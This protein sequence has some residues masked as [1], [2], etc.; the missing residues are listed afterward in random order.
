MPRAALLASILALPLHAHAQDGGQLFT[1]YCSACHGPDGKGATGGQFPPLAGSDWV[2]GDPARA[3]KIVLHGLHGEVEV[4]GRKFNLEMPPQGGVL[5]DDQIAAILSYVRSSWGN[6]AEAISTDFVKATRAATT[7]RKV[8]WTQA[9]IIKLHPLPPSK[10]PI[11]NLISQ[12][13]NGE[14]QSLPDFSKLKAT[15]V[16]EE[17]DGKISIKKAGAT[18]LFGM[19]WEGDLNVSEEG[20]YLFRL[21]AD[22]GARVVLDGKPVVEVSGIGPMDGGRA[23]NGS[24]KLSA[25]PHKIR[26]EYF[27]YKGN[28][29]I[30]LAWR[31]SDVPG[32]KSLTDTAI[33]GG[34]DPIMLAPENGRAV[35]Y[36]N[37]IEGTTPRGIGIGFPG[38]VNL[39]YSADNLAPELIWTGEFM[40]ASKHWTDRGQGNQSPAGD[41][42]VK[43]SGSPAFSGEARFRGYKLDPAG[44]PTFSVQVGNQFV[45]DSWKPGTA[46]G[47][48]ALVRTLTVNGQ[49]DAVSL[50]ISDKLALKKEGSASSLGDAI[51]LQSDHAEL[52]SRDGKVFVKIIPGQP[53][54]LTY[55][56]K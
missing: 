6:K 36:R 15:N 8:Q 22:D 27:E 39:A 31:K 11:A 12:V 33:K 41:H 4:D 43:L 24:A 54:T 26:V 23:K 35:V 34:R 29:G 44:N 21:D 13:Y 47:A 25:G 49:G 45:L 2:A 53:A 32:W 30:A 5:P 18:D 56:W 50:L 37:F 17:H 16:E 52:E 19:V 1:T 7:D 46:N 20:E 48:P 55:S 38:S 9:E 28:E 51:T 10:P 3:V 42:V 40:D 14:W